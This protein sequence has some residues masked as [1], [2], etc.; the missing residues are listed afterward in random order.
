MNILPKRFLCW[1]TER[2]FSDP[3]YQA[4]FEA[5]LA[6]GKSKEEAVKAVREQIFMDTPKKYKVEEVYDGGSERK[7]HTKRIIGGYYISSK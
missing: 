1:S 6:L 5:E 7:C 3:R 4:L 2:V